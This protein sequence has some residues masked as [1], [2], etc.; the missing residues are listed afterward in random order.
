MKALKS[1]QKNIKSIAE[2]YNAIYSLRPFR[3]RFIPI[4]DVAAR[5][6]FYGYKF[7]SIES[8]ARQRE[9]IECKSKIVGLI[10]A[11]RCG[12]TEAGAI[13][14]LKICLESKIEGEFWVLTE[15]FDLQKS[16]VKV[17]VDDYLKPEDIID[18]EY[19]RKSVYKTITVRSRHGKTV[20]I[21]F[22]TFEQGFAKLQSAK[23]IGAWI[24]EEPPEDVFDE[25]SL[26][27]IDLEGQ[28]ILTFTPRRGKT[29]SFNRIFQANDSDVKI[30][31][32]GMADN[33]FIPRREIESLK[34]QWSNAKV[35]M[36]LFG[37]YV[38]SEGAVFSFKPDKHMR[39]LQYDPNLPC[40]VSVD[41]GVRFTDV[42]FWQANFTA[43]EHYLIDH[44]RIEGAGYARAMKMILS[45]PYQ[46]QEYYCDPAGSARS[47]AS[48]SGLSLLTHI[49]DEFGIDFA[50]VKRVS[51]EES[52]DIVE[53]YFENADGKAR[54]FINSDITPIENTSHPSIYIENYVRDEKTNDPIKD[55]V[56][57][58]F[59]DQMRYYFV[60]ILRYSFASKF[61]QR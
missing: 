61:S 58:H 24:D 38:S 52:I 28:V 47:Q 31:N 12:K 33:P 7:S 54:L 17:K 60:N 8:N 10:A 48:K 3:R 46:I 59:C 40:F 22:K 26:R 11:N 27:T 45:K 5:P 14:A 55:G 18:V 42:G 36:C 23:I 13:K 35:R 20:R 49:K 1:S 25:V 34:R 39:K 53:S 44:S 16:G 15:S 4:E 32:W 43:D 6:E 30:F 19:I 56:N 2:K 21:E 37:E 50:F 9:F 41:W 51:I 57:D 29:W